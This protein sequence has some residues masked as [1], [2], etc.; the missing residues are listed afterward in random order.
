MLATPL[1]KLAINPEPT[2]AVAGSFA[3]FDGSPLRYA[4]WERTQGPSRGTACVFTGLGEYIEKYFEVVADLRR[5]GFAVAMMDWR[6]Q[7]GSCRLLADR[8]KCHV[9]DFSDFD[10]DLAQFM[11]EIVLPDCPPPY[12]GI[13]HS[14]GGNILLRNAVMPGTWF[15]RMVLSAPMIA[16]HPS[17]LRMPLWLVRSY[18][19]TV[20]L[21]GLDKRFAPGAAEWSPET[22][23]FEENQVT[24]D[25]VRYARNRAVLQADPSLVVGGVT[26]GWLRAAIR[27]SD[28]LSRP[29]FA[30]RVKLP[31]LFFIA[32]R[33]MIVVPQ[34]IEDFAS[35][36]KVGTHVI[37]A[38]ARHEILQEN[39]DIRGRFWAAFDAYMGVEAQV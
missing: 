26:N 3:G 33:D 20:C 32:G 12:L 9:R 22:T 29:E 6:G 4:R 13:A 23:P 5:R 14:M 30:T 25:H 17:Q 21:I 16:M 27:S 11:R 37:L 38:N 7:G 39:D 18:V 34:A 10:K 1:V 31:I 35:R 36:L 8:R 24:S 28:M 2:G 15:E 19:E